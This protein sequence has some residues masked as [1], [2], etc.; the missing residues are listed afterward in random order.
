[1]HVVLKDLCF[2]FLLF[3]SLACCSKAMPPRKKR[4]P[5][6]GDDMSAKKSRQD[7]CEIPL[8]KHSVNLNVCST[9]FILPLV[10]IQ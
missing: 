6:A 1:M 5:S 4:R 9:M 10:N 7:R 2:H 3:T 8:I